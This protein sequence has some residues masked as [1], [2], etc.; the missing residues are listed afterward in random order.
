LYL[1]IFESLGTSELILIGIVALMFLG[2]RRMPEIARKVG[3]MMA[4]LRGTANEFKQTWERE[5]DFEEETKALKIDDLLSEDDDVKPVP[6]EN[7]ILPDN[8]VSSRV[9]VPAIKAINREEFDAIA[10][11]AGETKSETNGNHKT[12]EERAPEEE[13]DLLSDKRNWL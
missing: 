8:E 7:S 3:K 12:A 10:A 1:F 13:P 5:V 9:D 4:D 2:P 6:R 11:A